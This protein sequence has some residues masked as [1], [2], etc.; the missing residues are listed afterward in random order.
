MEFQENIFLKIESDP[1]FIL[2]RRLLT[3]AFSIR[4]FMIGVEY[5]VIL[6]SALLYMKTFDV[7][8][9]FMG[10]VIAAYPFAGM[11][12]L[13]IFG[14]I[15]DKTKK[16]K[17]L[18]LLLNLFQIVGNIL[19]AIPFSKWLPLSGRFISGL[20]D[21]FIACAMGEITNIYPKSYRTAIMSLLELGRVLGLIIGPTI[22]FFIGKRTYYLW[23]WRL[24]YATLPGVIMAIGWMLMEFITVCCIFN[25]S[26]EITQKYTQK[27]KKKFN[28]KKLSLQCTKMDYND[29]DFLVENEQQNKTKSDSRVNDFNIWS[30]LKEICTLEFALI[31]YIDLIL[32]FSQ[33]EFEVMLPYLTEFDYH[34]S[35][36]WTG[37]VYMVGGLE[38]ILIFLLMYYLM[39]RF[40]IRDTYLIAFTLLITQVSLALFICESIPKDINHRIT[41]FIFICIM[42][43]T[44]IPFNLVA[45]KTFIS[46]ITN[47]ETQGFVQ[48]FYASITRIALIG[49]PIVGSLVFHERQKYGIVSSVCCGIALVGLLLCL[50]R[51]HRKEDEMAARLKDET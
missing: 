45:P 40:Q 12:S 24:D 10:L 47:P 26:L 46:K 5:S 48:G 29:T 9:V 33:T 38:L 18:I 21:G 16:T 30:A 3:V 34:W 43:F 42:V 20:G 1:L 49:G 7:S 39:R 32:W 27:V 15:Y 37:A 14:W 6:P 17:Q 44:S 36:A 19:Y 22:N 11:I 2:K 23:K 50:P 31:F 4:L 13:P 51:L 28:L 41:I 35:P 25:L 8:S